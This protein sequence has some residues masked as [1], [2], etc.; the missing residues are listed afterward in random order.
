[1]NLI[2]AQ[3]RGGDEWVG[4]VGWVGGG[5]KIAQQEGPNKSRTEK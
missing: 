3:F 4:G 2:F 1:M 5:P